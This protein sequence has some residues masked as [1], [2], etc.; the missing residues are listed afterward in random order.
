MIRQPER[1]LPESF[2]ALH[3]AGHAVRGLAYA[4]GGVVTLG[5]GFG[6]L[7]YNVFE[8]LH[9]TLETGLVHGAGDVAL[10]MSGAYLFLGSS[11][12]ILSGAAEIY[13]NSRRK[14]HRGTIKNTTDGVS[15]F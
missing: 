13:Y 4:V 8:G 1:S 3:I 5:G 12:N 15:W 9:Q 2:S 14:G 7:R 11:K 6:D 10:V